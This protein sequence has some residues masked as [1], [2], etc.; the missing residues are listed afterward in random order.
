[1]RYPSVLMALFQGDSF[2]V[3]GCKITA[4][5][6]QYYPLY[7]RYHSGYLHKRR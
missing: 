2:F 1:M 5:I 7:L 4:N 6:V 3:C